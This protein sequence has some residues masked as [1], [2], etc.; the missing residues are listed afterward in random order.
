MSRFADEPLHK[1]TTHIYASDLE[2]LRQKHA[3]GYQEAI[4]RIIRKHRRQI[5]ELEDE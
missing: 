5:E 1:I 3:E 2:W 4:R